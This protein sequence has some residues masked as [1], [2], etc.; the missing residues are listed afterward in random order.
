MYRVHTYSLTSAELYPLPEVTRTV[1]AG[2]LLPWRTADQLI[3]ARTQAVNQEGRRNDIGYF[4]VSDRHGCFLV[5]ITKNG[6]ES[7]IC[8]WQTRRHDDQPERIRFEG[9]HDNEAV[10][11]VEHPASNRML[12]VRGQGNPLVC[13]QNRHDPSE[14]IAIAT[15][16]GDHWWEVVSAWETRRFPTKAKTI[17]YLHTL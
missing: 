2:L 10:R 14:T 3:N 12:L 9:G 6:M 7:G 1:G 4:R 16:K 8:R 17:E 15:R 13:R 11:I 5:K